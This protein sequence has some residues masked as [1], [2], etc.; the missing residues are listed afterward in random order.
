MVAQQFDGDDGVKAVYY[1]R[2]GITIT[3]FMDKKNMNLDFAVRLACD[4]SG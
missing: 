2:H 1:V 3:F 4:C